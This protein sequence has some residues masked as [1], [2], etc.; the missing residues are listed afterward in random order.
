MKKYI[1]PN[2]LN[3][4]LNNSV[5]TNSWYNINW[6]ENDT[7]SFQKICKDVKSSYYK[8]NII[9]LDLT[10]Q[11]K[12]I[13]NKW[14]DDCIDI[15]NMT[16]DFIKSKIINIDKMSDLE[17]DL[18]SMLF[19]FPKLRKEL[20]NNI[21]HICNINNLPKHTGD[22]ALKH[23][24]TMYKSAISNHNGNLNKF[25]I[26]N[27][28]KDRRR[29]NLVIEPAN[30]S[31]KINS[32]CKTILG[33]INSNIQLNIIKQNSVLQYD[34]FKDKYI[35]ITPE[36]V[37]NEKKVY[38]YE[39]C[40][41]DIG[42]RTFL[43]TY[44]E[45]EVFEIGT[46]DITYKMIDNYNKRFTRISKSYKNGYINKKKY[47]YLNM[48]YRQRLRDKIDDMHRKVANMLLKRY[49]TIVIGN[50]STKQMI[51]NIKG[52]LNKITKKRCMALSHYRFRTKL[53]QMAIKFGVNVKETDEYMTS[54]TCHNC[55]NIHSDLGSKKIYNCV[56]CGLSLD[57]DINAAIN[58]YKDIDLR[59]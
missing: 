19:N 36:V 22:Y 55:N 32:F 20:N 5:E 15:Y 10:E 40:G 48:K 14:L 38:Q 49:Q 45:Q 1:Y 56:K 34:C 39:K 57:R 9:V 50:V 25:N 16:N 46:S 27:M 47:N 3:T 11:Q 6:I 43:T 28:M 23:C 35:I 41:I 7:Q 31:K 18:K 59:R 37:N 24:I 44:S 42:I 17:E 30:I 8:T 54:K 52:K 51:S 12:I 29:K 4:S 58:I 21:K 2:L 26:R 53:K 13:I 33:E